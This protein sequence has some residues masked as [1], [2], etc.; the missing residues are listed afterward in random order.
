LTF[1]AYAIQRAGFYAVADAWTEA[2]KL[3]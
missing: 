3:G 2:Q 1:T